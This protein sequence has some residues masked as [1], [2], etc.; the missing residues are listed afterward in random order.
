MIPDAGSLV[1]DLI[2][3]AIITPVFLVGIDAA[4]SSAV[5]VY[6]SNRR[7]ELVAKL[8]REAASIAET[9]YRAPL[10]EIAAAARRGAGALGVDEAIIARLPPALRRLQEQ[11]HEQ[12]S[13][14]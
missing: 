6:V 5:K 13:G 8:E 1:Y 12:A 7:R 3:E 11:V 4:T 14:Q 10:D 9:L 2:E